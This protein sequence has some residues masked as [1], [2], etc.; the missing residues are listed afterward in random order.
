MPTLNWAVGSNGEGSA[1]AI[2]SGNYYASDGMFN[3]LDAGEGLIPVCFE[4]KFLT[5]LTLPINLTSVSMNGV[6]VLPYFNNVFRSRVSDVDRANYIATGQFSL[7]PVWNLYDA[8]GSWQI[9][10]YS[11]DAFATNKIIFNDLGQCDIF[12]CSENSTGIVLD[13]KETLVNDRIMKPNYLEVFGRLERQILNIQLDTD[14][15]DIDINSGKYQRYIYD[16]EYLKVISANDT[17]LKSVNILHGYV[18]RFHADD[19]IK[20][21]FDDWTQTYGALSGSDFGQQETDNGQAYFAFGDCYNISPLNTCSIIANVTNLATTNKRRK[22]Y[23][24]K[25][26]LIS[27]QHS[28]TVINLMIGFNYPTLNRGYS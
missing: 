17:V 28:A 25:L 8:T 6:N 18:L 27:A 22:I 12:I 4:V 19:S 9:T 11:Y 2:L 3:V 16:N 20:L 14:K 15:F 26:T 1:S 5:S 13:L 23:L 7:A 10:V 21:I 24:R